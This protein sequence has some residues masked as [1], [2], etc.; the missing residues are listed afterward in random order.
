MVDDIKS[1]KILLLGDDGVGKS[2]VGNLILG[3]KKLKI[4]SL[5]NCVNEHLCIE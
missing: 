4:K 3:N 2:T 5:L 1:L